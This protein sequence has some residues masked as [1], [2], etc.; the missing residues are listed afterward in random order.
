MSE[1]YEVKSIPGKG[2]GCVALKEIKLG[3]MIL[4]EKPQLKLKSGSWSF[5]DLMI[6]FT[7][8]VE[9]IPSRLIKYSL[10]H[11]MQPQNL[12]NQAKT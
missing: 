12:F 8:L 4:Q 10:I 7:Q 11:K 5:Q 1:Y 6:A 9:F 2:M 3:T